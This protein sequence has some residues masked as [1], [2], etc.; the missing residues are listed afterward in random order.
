MEYLLLFLCKN[1]CTNMPILFCLNFRP[2]LPNV[3]AEY[4]DL[5]KVMLVSAKDMFHSIL[6]NTLYITRASFDVLHPSSRSSWFL[7]SWLFV[8]SGN[9]LISG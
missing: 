5:S 4:S 2:V 7:I 8:A 6:L 9:I 1:G 3:T